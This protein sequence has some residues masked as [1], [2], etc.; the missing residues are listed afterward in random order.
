[1]ITKHSLTVQNLVY[2]GTVTTELDS[3]EMAYVQA[4]GEPRIDLNGMIPYTPPAPDAPPG[5]ITLDSETDV[6]T[7]PVSGESDDN[8]GLGDALVVKGS[9]VF[10]NLLDDTVGFFKFA[11]E[12][13][14]DFQFTTRLDFF[15]GGLFEEDGADP[16]VVDGFRTGLMLQR[17]TNSNGPAILLGWGS[18]NSAYNLA[19]WH[20]PTEG[21]AFTEVNVVSRDNPSGIYLRLTRTGIT[22]VAEYS[23]D[24]AKTWNILGS[25]TVQYQSYRAGLFINS[26]TT[27]LA[28]ATFTNTLLTNDPE[29]VEYEFEIK[30]ERRVYVRSNSPHTFQVDGKVDSEAHAKV[31]GWL[32]EISKRSGDA[33]RDLL[34]N[35][36]DPSTV[37]GS[38]VERY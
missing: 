31:N 30:G 11:E 34:A 13:V 12:V 2:A 19:L 36:E 7:P 28:D 25:T 9:G 6:G 15:N 17:G 24:N 21:G 29:Q 38:Q 3:V 35:N 1:M 5:G 33:I 26:G 18:H 22:L 23:T 16:T 4:Y 14:G 32:Q 27:E 37:G 20:R 8:P 10:P